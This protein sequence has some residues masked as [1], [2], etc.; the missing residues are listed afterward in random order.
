MEDFL[1]KY[2][3]LGRFIAALQALRDSD[4]WQNRALYQGMKTV[5]LVMWLTALTA[6]MVLWFVALVLV[7]G[8]LLSMLTAPFLGLLAPFLP[9]FA[10]MEWWQVTYEF[11][12]KVWMGGLVVFMM[13]LCGGAIA[14]RQTRGPSIARRLSA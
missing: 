12:M 5:G 8:T 2:P 3:L 7:F 9:Y 4:E 10:A 6:L 14:M 13:A 1:A 11:G